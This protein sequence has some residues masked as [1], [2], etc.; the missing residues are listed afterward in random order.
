MR[1]L[2]VSAL[3]LALAACQAESPA[4]VEPAAPAAPAAPVAPAAPEA[5]VAAAAV[6]HVGLM[7]HEPWTRPLAPG[8]TV[9]AGYLQLMNHTAQADTLVSASAEGVGRVEIHD[10]EEVDGLMQMRPIDGGLALDAN[11]MVALQPGGKHLMFIDVTRSWAAGE[12]VPVT[13]AF[14]SGQTVAVDFDVRDGS[15][16]SGEHSGGHAH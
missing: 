14:A 1:L 2:V 3:T 6:A 4:P 12:R 9:A 15:P 16:E 10:M 5:P 7:A 11:A 13:L 8:A